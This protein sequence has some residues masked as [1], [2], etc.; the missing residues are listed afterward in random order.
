MLS[1]QIAKGVKVNVIKK[2]EEDMQSQK[3]KARMLQ[4]YAFAVNRKGV[5][6][7]MI[8]MMITIMFTIVKGTLQWNGKSVVH[9]DFVSSTETKRTLASK[10]IYQQ[11]FI[12]KKEE[13]KKQ[14]SGLQICKEEKSRM[15]RN[16]KG[17]KAK[18]KN[19]EQNSEI[20]QHSKQSKDKEEFSNTIQ[21]E[22][23]YDMSNMSYA[24]QGDDTLENTWS[25]GNEEKG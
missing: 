21:Y 24:H 7:S 4:N 25:R 18:E 16:K 17:R 23:G 5:H 13:W 19:E 2:L 8:F 11:F 3:M 10:V 20:R 1:V 9:A 22:G 15:K 14:L 12:E 6:W